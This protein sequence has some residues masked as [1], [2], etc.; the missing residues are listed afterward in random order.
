MRLKPLSRFFDRSQIASRDDRQTVF[1]FNRSLA[2]IADLESLCASFSVRIQERFAA[3]IAIVLQ[4]DPDRGIFRPL[5]DSRGPAPPASLI[6]FHRR[7]PLARW[8]LVNE[9]SLVISEC[10][11]VLRSLTE[12][13]RRTLRDSEIGVCTPMITLNRL[14]GIVLLGSRDKA[15]H[16]LEDD[17][18]LLELLSGLAGLALEN[19]SAYREQ[20]ERLRRL[21]RA[22]RLAA[23][24]Q[25][26]AGIAHEI[27]NPLTAIRSTVQYLGGAFEP[28]S[29]RAS[30]IAELLG[31]VDRIDRTVTDL[32]GLT[33]NPAPRK[34]QVDVA[35]L[36]EQSLALISTQA[37]QAGIDVRK[38]LP[39]SP[40]VTLG[41]PDLL[42]QVLINLL[43]NAL[44][45]M[46]GGGVLSVAVR[47]RE[48]DLV[49]P[50]HRWV[51]IEVRDSGPGISQEDLERVFDPFFTTKS[52]GTGLGLA[53]CHN[54]IE[55]H[56][57]EIG[58]DSAGDSGTT[59][60][61]RLSL[62]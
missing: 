17:L 27:R 48:P 43:L 22:E 56:D 15:W 14:T 54:I 26:A 2:L 29:E 19:A 38:E 13:E 34:L 41:D 36:V 16:L 25:L 30:L 28:G 53:V 24:G 50:T 47:R 6:E 44:Q 61:V 4:L 21:Y 58:I 32:L 1:E 62:T 7:G 3:E 59:A 49:A 9:K 52:N 12:G 40:L 10:P 20:R 39:G 33:R 37:R 11:G 60:W 51:Q 23:A 5:H 35:D 18:R 31:E 42:K 57:G 45:A 8:L 55:G 46:S